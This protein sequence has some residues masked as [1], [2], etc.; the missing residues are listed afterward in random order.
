MVRS[1]GW[2]W[3]FLHFKKGERHLD[4]GMNKILV[5]ANEACFPEC[6]DCLVALDFLFICLFFI[7]TENKNKILSWSSEMVSC[8]Q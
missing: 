8:S 4:L 1:V 7:F 6:Q 3:S 5:K 2:S